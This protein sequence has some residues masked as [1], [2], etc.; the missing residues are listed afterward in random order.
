MGMASIED[1]QK[2]AAELEQKL[3]AMVKFAEE[4]QLVAYQGGMGLNHRVAAF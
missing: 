4:N 1:Q 2:M 3:T